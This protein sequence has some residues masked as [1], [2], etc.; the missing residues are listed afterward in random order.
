MA[1]AL[2]TPPHTHPEAGTSSS[3]SSGSPPRPTVELDL[4]PLGPEHMGTRGVAPLVKLL[5]HYQA[6]WQD[7]HA[8][9]VAAEAQAAA[10]AAAAAAA[11][12]AAAR[13]QRHGSHG[14]PSPSIS[15][16]PTA[17][18]SR[19]EEQV[20]VAA[21][22]AAAPTP[23]V[24]E[25]VASVAPEADPGA[26]P[27]PT[28]ATLTDS[29]GSEETGP[30]RL[31]SGPRAHAPLLSVINLSGCQVRTEGAIELALALRANVTVRP[32]VANRVG[33]TEAS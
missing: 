18:P 23:P 19:Q 2:A 12:E 9:T 30:P 8:A 11:A 1:H 3:G 6:E 14:T 4:S 28:T 22:A 26:P 7:A 16:S 33:L 17:Q 29:S 5:R 31:P 10:K 20:A 13:R 15:R 24:P 21:T 25:A 32:A 27:T